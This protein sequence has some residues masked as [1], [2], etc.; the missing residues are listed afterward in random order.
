MDKKLIA[1][2]ILSV[3]GAVI[4]A[5]ILG[6]SLYT[7]ILL[8][9]F[10]IVLVVNIWGGQRAKAVWLGFLLYLVVFILPSLV[11]VFF[12]PMSR[13][14]GPIMLSCLL[15]VIIAFILVL[16]VFFP[17]QEM[18]R[19]PSRPLAVLAGIFLLLTV[20]V[21]VAEKVRFIEMYY[22][23]SEKVREYSQLNWPTII[24]NTS[25]HVVIAICISVLLFL[26]ERFTFYVVAPIF[27]ILN[28]I[29]AFNKIFH[30]TNDHLSNQEIISYLET[31]F[32]I[33]TE[34]VYLVND[35]YVLLNLIIVVYFLRNYTKATE[36]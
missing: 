15:I 21:V 13:S 11:A 9:A 29:L 19:T 20:I 25:F 32:R 16:A 18:S 24:F 23:A 7:V 34:V 30:F 8:P 27:L 26:R 5:L 14:L 10:V 22:S 28:L 33:G 4:M 31:P 17:G 12:S 3:I 35:I 6:L 36:K 1:A 2:A